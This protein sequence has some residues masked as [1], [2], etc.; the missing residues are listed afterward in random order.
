M[1]GQSV[2]NFDQIFLFFSVELTVT[3]FV[4]VVL[5]TNPISYPP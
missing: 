2:V 1:R 4:Q 3:I 5:E